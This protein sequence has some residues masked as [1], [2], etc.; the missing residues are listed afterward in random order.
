MVLMCRL[1][2]LCLFDP[3]VGFPAFPYHTRAA[4]CD[5]NSL[6]LPTVLNHLQFVQ[7]GRGV[8][9]KG[10]WSE[11]DEGCVVQDGAHGD[12]G[13]NQMALLCGCPYTCHY[14]TTKFLVVNL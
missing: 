5:P 8:G 2:R 11:L 10:H 14:L 6:V 7:V 3:D 12:D 4:G 13:G 9:I 1:Y